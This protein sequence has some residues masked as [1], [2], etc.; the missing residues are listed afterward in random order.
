VREV[1]S[2]ANGQH[3]FDALPSVE[4]PVAA[5]LVIGFPSRTP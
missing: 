5:K 3:Q 1:D 2:I 4:V